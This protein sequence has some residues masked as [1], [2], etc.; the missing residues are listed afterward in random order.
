[1]QEG[2]SMLI[3]G[4][5]TIMYAQLNYAE[6]AL[7]ANIIF[8]VTVVATHWLQF[9]VSLNCLPLYWKYRAHRPPPQIR[10]LINEHPFGAVNE[11][12]YDLLCIMQR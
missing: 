7:V 11:G 12:N 2:V 5:Q 10:N 1:M 3:L 9:T 6:Y 8:C 4:L